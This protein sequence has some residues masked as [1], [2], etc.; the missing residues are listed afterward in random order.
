M[1]GKKKQ[2]AAETA[3]EETARAMTAERIVVGFEPRVSLIPPEVVA[4]RRAKAMRRSLLWGV[5]GVVAVTIAGIGGTAALGLQAQ[6]GLASAQA[7]TTELLAEQH[8]F[9]EVRKVQDQVALTQAAQQVGASTEIDWKDYLQK[10]QATLP[11]DATMTSVTVDSATPLATYEQPT[12]PLQGARV[13]TLTFQATSPVLPV[14]PAWLTS[15]ATLPGFA[16]A[17]P[18]SVT[19]DETTKLYTVTITMHINDAAYDKRFDPK[20]K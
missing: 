5:L 6:L 13:A 2:K 8:T 9:I 18:G 7:Q 12:A 11:A 1:I 20:G 10:V 19:L 15:L 3:P 14:V 17:T 4:G 16:D